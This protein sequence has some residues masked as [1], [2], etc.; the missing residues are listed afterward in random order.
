[1]GEIPDQVSAELTTS[2]EPDVTVV[3]SPRERFSGIDLSINSLYEAPGAR[4]EFICVDGG[5]PA[6]I[7]R[8]LVAEARRRGFHLIRT[9]HYLTPNEARNL[10][11]PEVKTKYIAFVDNDV[12][13]APDWLKALTR[14]ADETG[15]DIVTPIVCYGKPVHTKI[16][17]AGGTATFA[18]R[19]G[20]RT[21]KT[22]HRLIERQLS[23]VKGELLREPTELAEFHCVLVRRDV[24]ERF[25]PLDGKLK[26]MHEHI[27]LCLTVRN[28]GGTVMF[29]PA[30]VVT[31][32]WEMP[33]RLSDLPYFFCRW[34]DDWASESRMHFERKWDVRFSDDSARIFVTW[35]RGEACSRA[36]GLA[37][38]FVGRRISGTLYEKSVDWLIRL[39]QWR[40]QW[41][42]QQL[43][44]AR[45]YPPSGRICS[46]RE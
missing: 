31:N 12:I 33:L 40:R 13:F 23:E 11:I 19:S 34:N 16:H 35:H 1:M 43:H 8:Y 25:G 3:M 27:D 46:P 2:I 26:S 36:R 4:F 21:I 37:R 45:E 32:L 6:S 29:E 42:M 38:K 9:K 17:F 39:A 44:R 28:A 5:G 7:R 24:F 15:A 18:S 22:A 14:C 20:K 41:H 30:S 10:A